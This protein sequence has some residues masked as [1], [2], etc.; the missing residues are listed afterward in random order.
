MTQAASIERNITVPA[1]ALG[2]PKGDGLQVSR[3]GLPLLLDSFDPSGCV[4]VALPGDDGA[5]AMAQALFAQGFL[6]E[7]VTMLRAADMN[8]WLISLVLHAGRAPSLASEIRE[9]RDFYIHAAQGCGW[10]LVRAADPEREA[11][12]LTEAERAGARSTTK[13]AAAKVSRH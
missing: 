3:D 5:R 9:L 13:Y 6:P 10:L 11:R 8:R 2:A 12:I 4:V 7:D 1:A